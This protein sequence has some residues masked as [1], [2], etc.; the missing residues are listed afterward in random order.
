MPKIILHMVNDDPIAGDIEDYPSAQDVL[1]T[2]KNPHR[3]DGKEI[4]YLEAD[5]NMM[6]IPLSR[7]SYIEIIN[8]SDDQLISF[9]RE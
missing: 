6:I 8:E 9:V 2:V 5:V 3:R 7:I 4:P 1:I